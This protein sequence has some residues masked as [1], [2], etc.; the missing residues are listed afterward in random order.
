MNTYRDWTCNGESQD[1]GDD[2]KLNSRHFNVDVVLQ[3]LNV[4]LTKISPLFIQIFSSGR[5]IWRPFVHC[6]TL[7]APTPSVPKYINLKCF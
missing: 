6:F 1:G 2:T 5:A 3:K 7:H 4:I